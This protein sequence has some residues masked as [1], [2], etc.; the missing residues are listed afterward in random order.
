MLFFTWYTKI[1]DIIIWIT[2]RIF[3][4]TYY[5][6]TLNIIFITLKASHFLYNCSNFV[7]FCFGWNTWIFIS[8]QTRACCG[9]ILICFDTVR[10]NWGGNA[11]IIRLYI[12]S[13]FITKVMNIIMNA[14]MSLINIQTF[15]IITFIALIIICLWVLL[16]TKFYTSVLTNFFIQVPI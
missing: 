13:S 8:L 1:C 15:F 2:C 14:S 7:T 12:T 4:I 9:M 11:S 5:F 10:L 3:N 6:P 16:V